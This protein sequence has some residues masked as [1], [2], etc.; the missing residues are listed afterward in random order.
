MIVADVDHG[1]SRQE[2]ARNLATR[3]CSIATRLVPDGDG[4]H[5]RFINKRERPRGAWDSLNKDQIDNALRF[6]PNG[7]TPIGTVLHEKVLQPYIFDVFARGETLK[8]PILIMTITD[9]C[10]T[11]EEPDTFRNAVVECGRAL[12]ERGYEPEG[13]RN[14]ARSHIVFDADQPIKSRPLPRQS[15]RNGRSGRA[16]SRWFGWRYRHG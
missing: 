6:A 2:L 15:H 13:K 9:G 8:R 14:A 4:V 16:V 3:M 5:L 11:A 1:P 10:P 12:V 7:N